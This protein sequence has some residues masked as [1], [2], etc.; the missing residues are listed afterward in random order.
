[1]TQLTS[2]SEQKEVSLSF[3]TYL[4][5]YK[6]RLEEFLKKNIEEFD[7]EHGRCFSKPILH[8][9]KMKIEEEIRKIDFLIM[10]T[11]NYNNLTKD[12]E[13]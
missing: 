9:S 4:R 13:Y 12:G 6:F 7:D 1:M 3:I 8:Q 2:V 5:H 10:S 11:T